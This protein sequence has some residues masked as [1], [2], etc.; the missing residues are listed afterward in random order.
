MEWI[1]S[2]H[3]TC[4]ILSLCGFFLRGI[5]MLRESDYLQARWVK[6]IPHVI[7]TLLLVTAIALVFKLQL[8]VLQQPWLMAKISALLIYISLGMI[9]LRYGSTRKI[10]ALAW[11]SAMLVYLYIVSIALSKSVWGPMV[12]ID[13]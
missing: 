11:F 12:F 9:A 4:A 5:W 13:I 7:D 3:I 1:K 6:V 8:P 10:R 2:T